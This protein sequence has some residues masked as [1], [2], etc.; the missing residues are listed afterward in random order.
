MV[1][2]IT[3][4][5]AIAACLITNAHYTGIYPTDL[6]ANGGL[7]GDVIFF[8]VSGYCLYDVKD[9][10]VHWYSKRLL[11]CYLPVIIITIVYMA[12]GFY[13]LSQHSIFWWYCYPTYYH[14]VASIIVLYVPFYFIMRTDVLKKRIPLIMILLLVLC[15]AIYISPLYDKSYYH[16]DNVREPIIRILF[17]ESMLLGAYFK[18]H[19]KEITQGLKITKIF[20]MIITFILY[21]ASKMLFSKVNNI[22]NY[23]ILNWFTIFA[24]LYF[25]FLFFAG[26]EN[27]LVKFPKWLKTIINYLATITLEIYVVQYVIIDIIRKRLSFPI[28]W[29][30]LTV[31]ILIAATILHFLCKYLLEGIDFMVTKIKKNER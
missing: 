4:L 7:I 1:F 18:Q 16:I 11:R 2:F 27:K 21:F 23:Q 20:G 10:F 14:F 29:I 17:M 12:L 31:S 5:R 8:A 22:S 30:V 24:L 28:N 19:F 3:F 9:S 15:M 6:I 26:L 25:V 13:S